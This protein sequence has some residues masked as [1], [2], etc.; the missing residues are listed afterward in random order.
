M[1]ID[2]QIKADYRAFLLKNGIPVEQ[3]N[4]F[5][6]WLNLY[7]DICQTHQ[8]QPTNVDHFP[9][10]LDAIQT[11][12]TS[13]F[14]RTQAEQAVRLY[15]LFLQGATP[16]AEPETSV[17]VRPVTTLSD[18]Q[19]TISSAWQALAVALAN[20]I[21]VRH[22][23][24]KTL[25]SYRAW[26]YR[27]YSFVGETP[28]EQLGKQEV[29]R[30]LTHLATVDQVSAATQNQ[31]LN[32]LLFVYK[33]VLRRKLTLLKNVTRAKR[34]PYIPVVLSR[35]EIDRIIAQLSPPYS[36]IVKL[37][38]GCGLRLNECLNLRIQ[39]LN[40]D[41]AILTIHNGKGQKDRTLP[42]PQVIAAELNEQ[43]QT[44]CQ[45][46]QQ[47]LQ[48][49]YQGVFLP[50]QLEQKY[51]NAHQQLSWQWLFPA[52]QLTLIPETQ[53]LRRYHLHET[54]VQ[55]AIHRAVKLA[56]IP[57]RAT[58]HSFRHSF[59]SHLLAANYDL[60]TIQEMMG[61][62]DIRTTLIYTHTVRSTTLK[63]PKSPLD[64]GC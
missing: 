1:M 39:D 20:E 2:Y 59:A 55:R 54:H 18:K 10:F 13:P 56:C 38:Y 49:G 36:L 53:Q 43:L 25:K 12:A 8:W 37:L 3:H 41:M 29:S 7:L 61:H 22:Y 11:Q 23:S 63:E 51:K 58:A 52:K 15:Q 14:L 17:T 44:I 21:R 24:P 6:R 4:Y 30:F 64:F 5:V 50:H 16:Q 9:A 42:I 62:S 31:A 40:L 47:D 26:L 48:E 45:Q 57:K 33:H 19:T 60:K 32:A 46:H 34:K 35:A 27:F 28:P